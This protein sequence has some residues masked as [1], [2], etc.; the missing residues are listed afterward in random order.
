MGGTCIVYPH[1]EKKWGNTS[2]VS[3]PNCGY[4]KNTNYFTNCQNGKHALARHLWNKSQN[5]LIED[6]TGCIRQKNGFQCVLASVPWP[7]PICRFFRV[8]L[9]LIFFINFY[10]C[11]FLLFMSLFPPRTEHS[12]V[13]WQMMDDRCQVTWNAGVVYKSTVEK[14]FFFIFW[15]SR[16]LVLLIS[17]VKIERCLSLTFEIGSIL[18]QDWDLWHWCRLCFTHRHLS[19]RFFAIGTWK[20]NLWTTN[21]REEIRKSFLCILSNIVV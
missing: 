3:P 9:L 2:P 13:I 15:I 14:T 10:G 4:E 7:W 11:H 19:S 12:L 18:C 16:W 6:G 17:S 1:R 5:E 20:L 21:R 8:G